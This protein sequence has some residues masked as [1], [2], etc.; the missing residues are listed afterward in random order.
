MQK[1]N[2]YFLTVL[3]FLGFGLVDIEAPVHWVYS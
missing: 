2:I 3:Q 1:K